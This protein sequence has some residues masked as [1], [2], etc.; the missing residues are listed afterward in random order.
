MTNLPISVFELYLNEKNLNPYSIL[1]AI[2]VM[3]TG[4]WLRVTRSLLSGYARAG[5]SFVTAGSGPH[6]GSSAASN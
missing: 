5:A 3:L 2:F 6:L 1:L 4:T